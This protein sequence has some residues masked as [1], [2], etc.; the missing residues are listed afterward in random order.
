MQFREYTWAQ[1]LYRQRLIYGPAAEATE[2]SYPMY[3]AAA[4]REVRVAG[5][6]PGSWPRARPRQRQPRVEGLGRRPA[7]AAAAAAA[8]SVAVRASGTRETK[9]TTPAPPPLHPAT[10][11]AAAPR[12]QLVR[13]SKHPHNLEPLLLTLRRP[14]NADT[15]KRFAE[16]AGELVLIERALS[17]EVICEDLQIINGGS[18]ETAPDGMLYPDKGSTVRGGWVGP[19]GRP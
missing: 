16:L 15:R 2:R 6:D 3:P 5:G 10:S 18:L 11:P 19:S 1:Q 14:A 9:H 7:A 4:L 12:P 8:A 13:Q 17:D